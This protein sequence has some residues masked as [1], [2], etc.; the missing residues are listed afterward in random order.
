MPIFSRAHYESETTQFLADLKL[1]K[2]HLEQSQREGRAKLWDKDPIDLDAVERA[3]RARVP[4][5]PYVYQT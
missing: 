4:Q 3:Q 5:K 2:P 1:A